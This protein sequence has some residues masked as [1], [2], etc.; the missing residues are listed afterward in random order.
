VV[1]PASVI[2]PKVE[3][4]MARASSPVAVPRIFKSPRKNWGTGTI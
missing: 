1:V 2:S 3:G 4:G